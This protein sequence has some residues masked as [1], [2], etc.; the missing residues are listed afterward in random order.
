MKHL[1]RLS[2]VLLIS[3]WSAAVLAQGMTPRPGG[4]MGRQPTPKS[5]KPAGPAE[6]APEEEEV[7]DQPDLPPLPPWPGQEAKKLQ[8]FQLK[9]YFRFRSDMFHNANLGLFDPTGTFRHPYYT[10]LSEDPASA[11]SC[12]KRYNKATPGGSDRDMEQDD[13]PASTLAGANMRLRLEP[14]INIGEQVRVHTQIDVFDNLS[15]G[16]TP[17]RGSASSDPLTVPLDAFA[18]GGSQ[19]PPTVGLNSDRAALIVKR[20]WAEVETPVGPLR[21]GRMPN[22]WGLG[23]VANAGDCMDCDYGDNV[24]RVSFQTTLAGYTLGMSY[25]FASSGPT[26]IGTVAGLNYYGG[27]AIDIEQL[28]DVIQLTWVAGKIEKEE[29][30]RDKV[31]RGQLVF[32]YGLYMV[33]RQQDF[34]Y[35]RLVASGAN[36][37]TAGPGFGDSK[38]TWAGGFVE[39]HYWSIMPDLWFKLLWKKLSLEFEGVL[40]AGNIEN[41]GLKSDTKNAEYSIFQFAWVVRSHYR[42][43]KDALSIGLEIGMAS[44]DQ[45]EPANQDPDRRRWHPLGLNSSGTRIDN[46]GSLREF[47]FNYDYHVDLI[48]FREILGTVANAVYFKPWVQYLVVDN[49]GARLDIIYSLAHQAIAT[50]GNNP[51]LGIEFDLDIFYRNISEKFYAGLQYGVLIPLDGLDW[52]PATGVAGGKSVPLFGSAAA[53]AEVAHTLQFRLMVKF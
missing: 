50:P 2:L 49:L 41:A 32:N 10:P 4:G 46:D 43:L 35:A 26:N 9:G 5:D 3:L 22:H 8:L 11:A 51:N 42:M 16:S 24:D 45:S 14:T 17:N 39:R 34:D 30:I 25:D 21:F 18:A 6:A 37:Y 23:M 47:R 19:A 36:T 15:M 33:W 27:Q 7:V 48:L 20:A 38:A 31:D 29:V 28:D 12:A 1:L 53:D 44:G 40:L 52:Q 13:C